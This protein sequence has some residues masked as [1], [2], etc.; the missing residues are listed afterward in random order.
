MLFCVCEWLILK[1][2]ELEPSLVFTVKQQWYGAG[3]IGPE[4]NHSNVCGS[5][6]SHSVAGVWRLF[7]PSEGKPFMTPSIL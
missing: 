5:P 4:S 1:L 7:C 2:S 3:M 6:K